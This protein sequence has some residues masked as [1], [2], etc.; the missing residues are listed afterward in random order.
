VAVLA[1]SA[2]ASAQQTLKI[3]PI[4]HDSDV[5][6]SFEVPDAYTADVRDAIASGLRTTFSYD[7]QLRMH[8]TGW[9]DRTVATAVITVT[10][11]FDNLTRRHE[12]TRTVDGRGQDSTTTDSDAVVRQWLTS[13]EKL[14]ICGTTKLEPNREYYV[15]VSA[16]VP[17]QSLLGRTTAMAGRAPFTFIR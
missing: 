2:V 11:K 5:L 7:V 16:R 15:S 17:S 4:V 9:V 12:L 10:D 3:V 13:L 8:V 6:V 14:T 1:A